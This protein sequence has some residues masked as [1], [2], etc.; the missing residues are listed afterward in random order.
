LG[1]D[2]VPR[3]LPRDAARGNR[4]KGGRQRNQRAHSCC[5]PEGDRPHGGASGQPCAEGRTEEGTVTH[6][7]TREGRATPP[8]ANKWPV[9]CRMNDASPSSPVREAATHP[10]QSLGRPSEPG[11][12]RTP[13]HRLN[14]VRRKQSSNIR[15]TRRTSSNCPSRPSHGPDGKLCTSSSRRASSRRTRDTSRRTWSTFRP[16][17]APS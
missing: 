9:L 6:D 8:A 4:A 1:S 14:L 3:H 11:A 7:R 10:R 5:A 13:K 15:A 12:S 16:L 17:A 2:G